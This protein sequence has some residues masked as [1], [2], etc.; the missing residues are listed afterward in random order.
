MLERS[1]GCLLDRFT[2]NS[3]LWLIEVKCPAMTQ[4]LHWTYASDL[5]VSVKIMSS[6]WFQ[7]KQSTITA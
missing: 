7:V 5:Q 6:G 2:V 4:T 1:V 3:P